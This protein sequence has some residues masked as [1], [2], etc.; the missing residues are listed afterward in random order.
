MK[1]VIGIGNALTDML[2]NLDSDATL[3]R[4]GLARGSMS[5]VDRGLQKEISKSVAGLP[6]TL[7]LGGSAANTIRAMARLGTSV[8]FIGKVGLDSTGDFF[9]Q[10]LENLGIAPV[11]FRGTEP[12][13]RCLALVSPDGERTMVTYLGAALEMKAAEILPEI[14]KDYDCLYVEGYLV[15]DH[16][17]IESAIRTAKECGL[18][19]AI[20]LASFNVVEENKEFLHRIVAEYVDILFANE[21]EAKAFTGE[22]EP[23]NALQKIS[24]MCEL[25]IVKIGTRGALIK[26]GSEVMHVGIMAAAK[27]VDTTGAGDF[28]A[29]GFMSG[30]CKGLS[31][32]QC[33]TIGAIAAGKVIEVVG[34]TF[35]EDAWTDMFALVRKVEAGQ[36]LF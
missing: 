5:L 7:S 19:I 1:R 8:G 24:E 21:D 34:T 2:I 20:D 4:F 25:S 16:T 30:L 33:G 29:A 17:L 11:I 31:L 26:R 14:F 22:E 32:R 27:R 35:G 10:A 18:K 15:Q 36:Y 13:G 12:S 6:N 3:Q 9:E 23:V 28:Y